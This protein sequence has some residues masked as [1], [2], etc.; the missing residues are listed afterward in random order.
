MSK[1][2]QLFEVDKMFCEECQTDKEKAWMKYTAKNS[3]MGTGKHL[4]YITDLKKI[5]EGIGALFRLDNIDF[6]WE[7]VYAFVSEDETL[8]VTTGTY[9]RSYTKDGEN[10]IQIGKYCTTWIKEDGEWKIALDIGN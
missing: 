5:R 9:T 7:P 6:T 3:V 1:V 10:H 8:G 2:R 4:P